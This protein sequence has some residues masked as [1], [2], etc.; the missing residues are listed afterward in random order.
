M[1][2]RRKVDAEEAQVLTEPLEVEEPPAAPAAVEVPPEPVAEVATDDEAPTELAAVAPAPSEVPHVVLHLNSIVGAAFRASNAKRAR[3]SQRALGMSELGSCRRQAGFK[4]TNA[5]ETD[6]LNYRTDIFADSREAMI[7]SLIHDLILPQIAAM[8]MTAEIEKK[9]VLKFDDLP[10]IPGSADLVDEDL[11]VDLKTVGHNSVQYYQTHGASKK[12][13]WQTHGYA[14]ALIESGHPIRHVTL[15]YIDR[16]NGQVVHVHYQ[17][18]DPAI[19]EDV[20]KWWTEVNAAEDPMDLPRDEKGPGISRQCDWCCAPGTM[21]LMPDYTWRAIEDIEIG[22]TIV[23]WS[24][25]SDRAPGKL[26]PTKVTMT[27]RRT[28]PLVR[29]NGDLIVAEGKRFHTRFGWRKT[30]SLQ[31]KDAKFVAAPIKRD[32]QMYERGWLAGMADGT[33][34][35]QQRKGERGENRWRNFLPAPTADAEAILVQF[36]QFASNAGFVA[37]REPQRTSARRV[38]SSLLAVTIP[39]E[40]RKFNEWV[41]ESIDD[42]SW[43]W[44]Y[45]GGIVDAKGSMTGR[46]G[47]IRILQDAHM[48]TTTHARIEA[49]L[50]RVGL[51]FTTG[52]NVWRILFRDGGLFRFLVGATPVRP[53]FAAAGLNRAPKNSEYI[54]EVTPAGE[55]EVVSLTTETGSYVAEGYIVHNCPWL[56]ACWGPEAVP[57]TS[58]VQKVILHEATDSTA[59]VVRQ[60]EAYADA[61]RM[62]NDVKD[63]KKFARDVLLGAEPG[64][65]GKYVLSWTPASTYETLDSAAAERILADAGIPVPKTTRDRSAMIHVKRAPLV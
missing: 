19:V 61:S 13:L 48:S 30:Q 12:H 33:K 54:H 58:G 49:A 47:T 60:L 18:F 31:G 8:S 65:Y 22:D 24:E 42:E 6:P 16:S 63:R 4:V 3:S 41:S 15:A 56:K 53:R 43:T 44:G 40:A 34:A 36:A 23:G 39:V 52:P 26:V 35:R 28:A 2:R 37:R 5:T 27:R 57:G 17:A 29:V 46:D 20:R 25:S 64:R 21:V 45:L 32:Q 9:V 10:E 1:A 62:E 38:A 50:R 14:Q 11:L 7:G 51:E 55:G 59:E